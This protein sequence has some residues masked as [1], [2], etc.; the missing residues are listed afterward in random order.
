MKAR[1][2]RILFVSVLLFY[3]Y[4]GGGGCGGDNPEPGTCE[5]VA[6]TWYTV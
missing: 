5:Q 1:L 6:G 3:A 2:N 4:G